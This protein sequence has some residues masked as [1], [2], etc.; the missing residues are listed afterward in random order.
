MIYT[1]IGDKGCNLSGGQKMRISMARAVYS[2]ADIYLLDEPLASLDNDTRNKIMRDCICSELKGK[3][4]LLCTHCTEFLPNAD[5]ILKLNNERIEFFGSY[6]EYKNLFLS[7]ENPIEKFQTSE[8]FFSSNGL[9]IE[10]PVKESVSSRFIAEEDE[11][12]G[13][14]SKEVFFNYFKI[15]GGV[16][17]IILLSIL[18]F[19][20]CTFSTCSTI[21]IQSWNK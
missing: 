3:T 14:V 8:K 5:R 4:I 12:K 19:G 17:I 7:E 18:I 2:D 21:Y 13:H 6:K 15:L 10:N 9:S 16:P 1:E 11:E 20:Y